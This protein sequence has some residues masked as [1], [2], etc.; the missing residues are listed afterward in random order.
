MDNIKIS[1]QM[2][3]SIYNKEENDEDIFELTDKPGLQIIRKYKQGTAPAKDNRR[4]FIILYIKD[5]RFVSGGI[6]MVK[7]KEEDG[8]GYEMI[9]DDEK[10][11]RS[12]LRQKYA[13]FFFDD[14][15]MAVFDSSSQKIIFRNNKYSVNEFVSVLVKNHLSD[16]FRLNRIMIFLKNYFILE[17]LFWLADA[18]YKDDNIRINFLLQKNITGYKESGAKIEM[19]KEPFFKYF[20]IYKNALMFFIIIILNPLLWL[21]VSLDASYF[22]IANPFL[23]FTA[24][25]F[26][27]IFSSQQAESLFLSILLKIYKG[28]SLRSIP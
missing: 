3:A 24:F 19:P 27:A 23:L 18:N 15:E 11:D 17:P 16:M 22:N 6:N 9:F 10:A 7:A 2:I 4:M 12:F 8:S 26:F 20:D 21:S 1:S 14:D 5:N 28:I 25:L 13:N